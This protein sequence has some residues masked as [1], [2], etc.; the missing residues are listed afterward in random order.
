VAEKEIGIGTGQESRPRVP[1]V[2]RFFFTIGGLMTCRWYPVCPMKWLT[3]AGKLDPGWTNA[4]CKG[5][6][7]R[8]VRY[9]ME[10]RGEPHPDDMLPDGSID[11]GLRAGS[12]AQKQYP[13]EEKQAR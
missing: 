3:E 7:K 2:R 11:E 1:G 4:F 12:A 5:D 13:V 9:Q 8:C 10:Q 6:W